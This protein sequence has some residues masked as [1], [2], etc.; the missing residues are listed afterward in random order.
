[1]HCECAEKCCILAGFTELIPG[2]EQGININ[3]NR[4]KLGNY[5]SEL[6]HQFNL[7]FLTI[8]IRI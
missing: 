5:K 1:M 4:T 8:L 2:P 7:G 3:Q 6:I